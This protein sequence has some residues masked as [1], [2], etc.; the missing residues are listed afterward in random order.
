MTGKFIQPSLVFLFVLTCPLYPQENSVAQPLRQ[1]LEFITYLMV[2][3]DFKESL[4]LLEKLDVVN[5]DQ[6]DS[7]LFLKGW[8]HYRMKSLD[9]SAAYLE[10]VSAQSPFYL[11]SG[12]F[13]AY[14]YAHNGRFEKA[15]RMLS[16]FSDS[17]DER[18]SAL[19]GLQQAGLWLL[20]RNMDGF[21]RYAS[22]FSGQNHVTATQEARMIQY[23]RELDSRRDKSPL[24]AGLLSA[25]IPGMGKVYA[26]K[27]AEGFAGLLYVS[28]MGV[29]AWDFYRGRGAKDPIFIIS[30]ALTGIFYAGN[31]TGS[32]AT[33][34]RVNTEFYHEMD[35]RILFDMH[36][37]LRSFF[38]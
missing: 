33:A 22:G 28:A 8:I 4:F 5:Q 27:P 2:R 3:D 31:I 29:T 36:I 1:E 20:E 34:R 10:Q 13:S 37:P 11:Q 25:L 12:L 6:K 18:A 9:T 24:T 16:R 23:A 30:A 15:W 35:Q 19:V 7:V 32:V 17:V 14:N 38:R 26:G 21:D